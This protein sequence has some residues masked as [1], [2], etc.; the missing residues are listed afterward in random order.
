MPSPSLSLGVTKPVWPLPVPPGVALPAS[1]VRVLADREAGASAG[2]GEPPST[3]PGVVASTV[4][5]TA[6]GPT[7][8]MVAGVPLPGRPRL[9]R[10]VCED[11]I[12][13]RSTVS[14]CSPPEVR[15]DGSLSQPT[16]GAAIA[17]TPSTPAHSPAATVPAKRRSRIT[18]REPRERDEV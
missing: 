5:G 15:A 18:G 6:T 7:T 11:G 9:S 8:P 2:A 16:S 17:P 14:V 12:A 4:P 3:P 13:G 1:L 10:E